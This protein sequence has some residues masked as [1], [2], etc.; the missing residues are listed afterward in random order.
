MSEEE[1]TTLFE[2][3]DVDGSQNV[4]HKELC[5]WFSDGLGPYAP[6]FEAL[7][8]ASSGVTSSLAASAEGYADSDVFDQYRTRFLLRE[9]FLQI[10]ALKAPL[11]H[12]H[13]S[14][15]D[16]ARLD[17]ERQIRSASGSSTNPGASS[18]SS[19]SASAS[20]A[21]PGVR[22]PMSKSGFTYRTEAPPSSP[23][24]RQS[25]GFD[26]PGAGGTGGV[27][28]AAVDALQAQIDRLEAL[29]DNYVSKV[30][31][32]PVEEDPEDADDEAVMVVM[33]VFDVDEDA[34]EP[35]IALASEYLMETRRSV[36]GCLHLYLKQ[37]YGNESM[38]MFWE[39]WESKDDVTD[40]Y[41][42][43]VWRS[44]V[45]HSADHLVSPTKTESLP[46][47]ASWW[48]FRAQ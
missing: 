34:V 39:V 22:V 45:K 33:R 19:A 17:R 2:K 32:S 41:M 8:S 44:F 23:A 6:L 7:A 11:E 12:A 5:N 3:I 46:I 31:F 40:H 36:D 15:E 35:F 27:P 38:I 1:L 18:S 47:P 43:P 21:P 25:R 29:A 24:L 4:D 28:Q 10:E 30:K 9:A 42:G 13:D 20:P 16:R 48:P 14:L 26:S 37:A